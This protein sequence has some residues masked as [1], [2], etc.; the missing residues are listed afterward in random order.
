MDSQQEIDKEGLVGRL[1][2]EL[3]RV[4]NLSS[5]V[6]GGVVT[7][8][9]NTLSPTCSSREQIPTADQYNLRPVCAVLSETLT[10]PAAYTTTNNTVKLSASNSDLS[11]VYPST[12]P[13]REPG[14][15]QSPDSSDFIRH[16]L[17]KNS[18][19]KLL[20]QQK[21][22]SVCPPT[23]VAPSSYLIQRSVFKQASP[24]PAPAELVSAHSPVST[25]VS[26]QCVTGSDILT[27]KGQPVQKLLPLNPFGIT[28]Q[29]V[30]NSQDIARQQSERENLRRQFQVLQQRLALKRQQPQLQQQQQLHLFP[31]LSKRQV[32]PESF[33][34]PSPVSSDKLVL[35]SEG[36][37][38]TV[39]HMTLSKSQA[40]QAKDRPKHLTEGMDTWS[41]GMDYPP[42][43][44]TCGDLPLSMDFLDASIYASS[45]NSL[46]LYEQE[47]LDMQSTMGSSTSCT[48]VEH[49]PLD[50]FELKTQYENSQDIG[51]FSLT[52]LSPAVTD[53]QTVKSSPAE[54]S[55]SEISKPV[56]QDVY[57]KMESPDVQAPTLAELNLNLLDDIESYINFELN[58]SVPGT[59]VKQETDAVTMAAVDLLN[60]VAGTESPRPEATVPC[61]VK[62]EPVS[63]SCRGVDRSFTQT[64]PVRS[65]KVSAQLRPVPSNNRLE[66]IK[67]I[68]L[69]DCTTLQRLLAQ[70]TSPGTVP[71]NSA[72]KRTVSES[73]AAQ[74]IQPRK[75]SMG[76]LDTMDQKW[77]EIKQFLENQSSVN[78]AAAAP[79]SSACSPPK[80]ERR[81]YDSA[82]SVM[83][84]TSNEDDDSDSDRDYD[85][86]SDSDFEG[87]HDM[88]SLSPS[89]SLIGTKEKQYFWQYNVQSK[90]P[91]GTRVKFDLEEDPHALNDFEDPV[92]GGPTNSGNLDNMG[93]CIKHGGKAR[94]GD[95]NDIVPSPKK[96]CQIGLQLRKINRQI[97]DFIPV[98][99]LP[100]YARSKSRKEKNK[101]ASRAC[102]LKKKAQHEANKVKLHGLEME[103]RRL[104]IVINAIRQKLFERI[105]N[106]SSDDQPSMSQFLEALI[107][108]HLSEMIAGNTTEFVNSVVRKVE[109]G[110][111]TGGI[112][113][114][115]M[116]SY[117]KELHN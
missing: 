80:R 45:P 15:V 9:T 17:L 92:F 25:P 117:P 76:A 52:E 107:K 102:R 3:V 61:V 30:F 36:S 60:Q 78:T 14:S 82:S 41:A 2:Q 31:S 40:V 93:V 47:K 79:S 69:S 38:G 116:R 98:S 95:G 77:E 7:T 65:D 86:D 26:Q 101:L 48:S 29:A 73:Q 21:L 113:R 106:T 8:V 64:T 105:N 22:A 28:Q 27:Q 24:S 70:N 72:R 84:L 111:Q 66:T 58:T 81:R 35:S 4:K 59:R 85:D 18:V 50:D 51:S 109:A 11:G 1:L 12:P 75:R 42:F 34:V 32:F 96:L 68:D 5:A 43:V 90:G 87:G 115:A 91:K 44:N 62:T 97:S 112:T 99:E 108:E 55:W 104:L 71:R 53:I 89:D 114:R 10:R 20:Q 83:T 54:T 37:K 56:Q 74:R 33:G 16:L 103:H 100:S 94:K 23:S 49:S 57:I 63:Q 39:Q 6:R 110:D 13:A 88:E 67:E 46:H 19:Q